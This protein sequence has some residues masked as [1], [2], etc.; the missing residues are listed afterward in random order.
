MTSFKTCDFNNIP[1]HSLL[2]KAIAEDTFHIDQT[3]KSILIQLRPPIKCNWLLKYRCR[4]SAIEI[5]MAFECPAI[6]RVYFIFQ[7]EYLTFAKSG[8]IVIYNFF[9]TV[10]VGSDYENHFNQRIRL[11][12]FQKWTNWEG[13]LCFLNQIEFSKISDQTD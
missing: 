7:T 9:Y 6:S 1:H 3:I 5:K 4:P 12:L 2:T 8:Y 10:D 11:I 13:Y